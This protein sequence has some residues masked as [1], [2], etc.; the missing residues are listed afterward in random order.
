MPHNCFRLRGQKMGAPKP[1]CCGNPSVLRFSQ[2]FAPTLRARNSATTIYL[3]RWSRQ[4][5]N[6]EQLPHVCCSKTTITSPC[7]L[8]GKV[9][10]KTRAAPLSLAAHWSPCSCRSSHLP[11][12]FNEIT[13]AQTP[14]RFSQSYLSLAQPL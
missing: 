1:F 14:E 8:L 11:Q 13:A 9:S 10:S 3:N 12:P 5:E 7:H 4:T 6:H 2:F